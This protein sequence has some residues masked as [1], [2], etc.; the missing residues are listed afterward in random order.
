MK[1]VTAALLAILFGVASIAPAIAQTSPPM[2]SDP[3]APLT[4]AD[5]KADLAA[6]RAAGFKPPINFERYPANAQQAGRIVAEQSAQ[7][8]GQH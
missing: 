4:R 8:P 1:N 5:V 6:W 7:A 2:S 3:S